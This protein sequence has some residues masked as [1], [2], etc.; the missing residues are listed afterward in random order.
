MATNGGE[1]GPDACQQALGVRDNVIVEGR[2]CAVP[3]IVNNYDP[4]A[5]W[6]KDPGGASPYAERIA[7]SMLENVNL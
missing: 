3:N 2:S 6:P 5:G 7:K 4:T 1:N